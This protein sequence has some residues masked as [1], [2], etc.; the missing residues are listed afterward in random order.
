[1]GER[2]DVVAVRDAAAGEHELHR[3][4]QQLKAELLTTAVVDDVRGDRFEEAARA[5]RGVVV[6]RLVVRVVDERPVEVALD[7]LQ[8][9]ARLEVQLGYD[10]VGGAADVQARELL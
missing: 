7:E 3:V 1:A 4:I 8:L 2:D 6:D 9:H 5:A 10:G